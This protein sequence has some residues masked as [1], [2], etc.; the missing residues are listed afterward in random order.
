LLQFEFHAIMSLAIVTEYRGDNEMARQ[1]TEEALTGAR[2][3]LDHLRTIGAPSAEV[4]WAEHNIVGGLGHLAGHLSGC[5]EPDAALA[6]YHEAIAQAEK[7]GATQM[8]PIYLTHV[9]AI[10]MSQGRNEEAQPYLE[11]ALQLLRDAGDRNMIGWTLHEMGKLTLAKGDF[12]LSGTYIR[13]SIE[14]FAEHGNVGALATMLLPL[15]WLI[16][17]KGQWTRAA[18]VLGMQEALHAQVGREGVSSDWTE[19]YQRFV[20][21]TREAL[22]AANYTAAHARG[23]SMTVEQIIDDSLQ[24]T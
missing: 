22:G 16:W 17:V 9:A 8:L 19:R 21:D 12:E 2:Q 6:L 7:V 13:E 23:R 14:I 11:R 10:Y 18:Q 1:L 5:G 24:G 4:E 20:H 3:H 15:C